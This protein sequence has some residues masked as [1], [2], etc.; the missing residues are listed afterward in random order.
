MSYHRSAGVR[1]FNEIALLINI[2]LYQFDFHLQPFVLL[3][4]VNVK[5]VIINER[6]NLW[7]TEKKTLVCVGR[8]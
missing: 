4:R 8:K 1:S 2:L 5:Y 6:S 7:F 3:F